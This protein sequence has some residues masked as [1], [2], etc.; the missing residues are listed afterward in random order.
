MRA[1]LARL[2]EKSMSAAEVGVRLSHLV[3]RAPILLT[4]RQ[5]SFIPLG[6]AG[7]EGGA[8]LIG[9]ELLPLPLP[10]LSTVPEVDLAALFP[11]TGII[12]TSAKLLGAECWQHLLVA[13]LNGLDSHGNCL[14][15]FGPP[16]AA[17][18]RALEGL[19]L[20][21]TNFVSDEKARTPT[22]FTKQLGAKSNSYWGEPVYTAEDLTLEQ[23]IPTL[24]AKGVAAS[25]D[26]I[27]VLE[28]QIRDQ[29]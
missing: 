17:Q 7:E 16:T 23:V 1:E 13:A 11:A 29:M 5:G 26:I 10:R 18:K 4:D 19:L 6:F 20:D 3:R 15:I 22:D 27:E 8:P 21:C 2:A 12:S 14:S 28:G 9:R 24:P 25:V